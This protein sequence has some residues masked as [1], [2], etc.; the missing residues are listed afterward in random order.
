MSTPRTKSLNRAVELLHAVAAQPAGASAA[1]LARATGL[2]RSTVTRTLHTLADAGLVEHAG[3]WVLG[4][5]LVRLA[6][7]ADPYRGLI[8]AARPVLARLRDATDE[9]ALLALFRDRPG[10]E[11]VLQL[12]P[13]R[14]VGVADWVGVEV[15]LHASAAGKLALAELGPDE[16]AD[17]LAANPPTPFTPSTLTDEEALAAELTRVRRLGWAELVDELEDG[18]ASL[19]A[20]VRTAD[21]ELVGAVGVSGPTFRLGRARRRELLPRL[22]AAAAEL[23][24]ALTVP[25][26]RRREEPEPVRRRAGSRRG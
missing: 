10:M 6:R 19:A 25:R 4:Y 21:G 15:P 16:L 26:Q 20:G 14:H 7:A 9:S 22:H 11:I 18:L 2:P 12:D 1:E 17:W 23:A 24:G 8:E 13:N 3:E 5:E